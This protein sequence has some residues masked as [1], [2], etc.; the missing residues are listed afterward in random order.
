LHTT[1]RVARANEHRR[2]ATLGVPYDPV[3]RLLGSLFALALLAAACSGNGAASPNETHAADVYT[4]VLRQLAP[5][6]NTDKSQQVV[7]VA[8]FAEQKAIS[9]ETQAA[10]IANLADEA[11]VRFVDELSEAVDDGNPGSPAK[12]A[13]VI[14]LGPV[15]PGSP[16]L[17]VEAQRYES[18]TDQTHYRFV[19]TAGAD[20]TLSA[21]AVETRPL[22]PTTTT[23]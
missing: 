3:F 23:G 15:P 22:A 10:V 5:P 4:A 2:S 11:D 1:E 6:P 13:A 18:D 9:L 21:A 14:L 8:P 19:V 20:G 17:E 12:G 16:P 7:Y